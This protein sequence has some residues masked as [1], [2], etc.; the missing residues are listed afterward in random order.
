MRL[1]P[2]FCIQ[3]TVYYIKFAVLS[4]LKKNLGCQIMKF[5]SFE[6]QNA[7][8]NFGLSLSKFIP[9]LAEIRSPRKFGLSFSKFDPSFSKLGQN[10][11]KFDPSLSKLRQNL[12]R[13][14]QSFKQIVIIN[15]IKNCLPQEQL[16]R[17]Q[18]LELQFSALILHFL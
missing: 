10:V 13:L 3:F 7:K 11:S 5:I 12:S 15:T 8:E 4:N 16:Q 2:N 17:P 6:I 9:C 18:N 1:N 14:G